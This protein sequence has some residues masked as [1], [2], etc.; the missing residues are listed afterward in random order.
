MRTSQSISYNHANKQG[1]MNNRFHVRKVEKGKKDPIKIEMKN[2]G[3][4]NQEKDEN[5]ILREEIKKLNEEKDELEKQFRK[6]Y[7]EKEIEL[8]KELE[9]EKEQLELREKAFEAQKQEYKLEEREEALNKEK[10]I[11]KEQKQKLNDKQREIEHLYG[12]FF[13]CRI[14]IPFQLRIS[15]SISTLWANSSRILTSHN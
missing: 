8:R 9:K 10:E 14:E 11:V 7:E 12:F 15:N 4:K 6:K 5:E 3:E 2:K 13:N 1:G